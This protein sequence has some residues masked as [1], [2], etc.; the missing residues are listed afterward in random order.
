M[1]CDFSN[2]A[3]YVVGYPIHWY[4]LAYIFGLLAAA[5]LT[6]LLA[7]E[8]GQALPRH[9]INEFIDYAI[10]GIILGGRFGHVLIY[11]F[12]YYTANPSEILKIWKGG[13][14]FYGGFAGVLMAA[15]LFCRKRHL[16]LLKFMDLWAVSVPIGLFLGRI[17][18]FI[19]GELLGTQTAVPWAVIFPDGVPRHPSQLYEAFCEGILLFVLLLWSF[20]HWKCHEKPG[21][22][23]GIFAVGYGLARF[24]CEFFREAD[25]DFSS[26]LLLGTGLNLNQYMSMC[27]M[28][29]GACLLF[30]RCSKVEE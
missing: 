4:S 21:A 8:S 1:V 29:G 3:F 16:Q 28:A 15:H 9:F 20:F 27:L 18:N 11:D 13:M 30:R 23:C 24:I 12:D 26:R 19:N 7:T 22:L 6:N 14:S 2:V 25:S 17:A 10:V 5:F